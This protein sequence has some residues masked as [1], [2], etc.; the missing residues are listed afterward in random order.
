LPDN[1]RE[2]LSKLTIEQFYLDRSQQ[3]PVDAVKVNSFVFV[4]PRITDFDISDQDHENS[5]APGTITAVFNFDALY[6]QTGQPGMNHV[7]PNLAGGDILNG[8]DEITSELKRS[9]SQA[10]KTGNPFVD[11][12]ANQGARMVQ[13]TVSGVL[14]KAFGGVAGGALAGAIGQVSGALGG[15]AK[16]TLSGQGAAIASGISLPTVPFVRDNSTPAGA[17]ADLSSRTP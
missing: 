16:G 15:A 9:P 17:S 7:T 8:L 6:I 1:N 12:I 10:G 3:R 11:I 2:I 5:G 4:N 13:S 14:N